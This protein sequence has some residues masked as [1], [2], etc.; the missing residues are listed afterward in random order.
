MAATALGQQP[1]ANS[2][3]VAHT[4]AAEASVRASLAP[5][6]APEISLSLMCAAALR[7]VTGSDIQPS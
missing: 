2:L 5:A 7:F 6:E 4:S 3:S 1:V